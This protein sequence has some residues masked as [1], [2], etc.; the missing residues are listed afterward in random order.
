MS[1]LGVQGLTILRREYTPEKLMQP[2]RLEDLAS[3][4]A[5]GE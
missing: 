1:L 5:L 3:Y 2:L 4:G